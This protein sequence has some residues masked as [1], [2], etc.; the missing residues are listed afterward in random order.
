MTEDSAGKTLEGAAGS[1]W[2]VGL[3]RN[4]VAIAAGASRLAGEKKNREILEGAAGKAVWLPKSW[5]ANKAQD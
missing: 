1:C 5:D 4:C 3:P 2:R